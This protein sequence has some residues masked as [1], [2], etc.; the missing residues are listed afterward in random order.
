MA[1]SSTYMNWRGDTLKDQS[2]SYLLSRPQKRANTHGMAH[3]PSSLTRG[4]AFSSAESSTKPS[5]PVT[6]RGLNPSYPEIERQIGNA[7]S[8]LP[9]RVIYEEIPRTA[10]ATNSCDADRD[11]SSKDKLR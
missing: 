9:G 2:F 6:L 8:P 4:K 1:D 10:D 11:K 7:I 5:I 3:I